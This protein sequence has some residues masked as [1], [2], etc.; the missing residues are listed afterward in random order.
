MSMWG[1]SPRSMPLQHS[2]SLHTQSKGCSKVLHLGRG[3]CLGGGVG[4][5]VVHWTINKPDGAL[6]N[7]PA[8]P[9]VLHVDVL[10]AWV[11]LV[12]THECNGRLIVREQSG[13]GCDIAKYLRDEA[14]KPQGL[15]ASMRCC[16][17][18]AF[19][20]RQGDNLLS[21]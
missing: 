19:S 16:D 14:A 9:V 13:G 11:V 6:L 7:D 8:N 3:Q 18:L 17:V 1:P 12:V 5:H 4:H 20:G 10:C 2:P 21:L 15:L